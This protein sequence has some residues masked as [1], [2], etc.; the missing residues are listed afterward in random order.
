VLANTTKGL[1]HGT[2]PS[3]IGAAAR[4]ASNRL[5]TGPAAATAVIPWRPL[6]SRAG[7][8]GTGFPQPK[9]MRSMNNVPAGS[10]WALGLRVSRPIAQGIRDQR[11]RELVEGQSG[12]QGGDHSAEE[13]N[14]ELHV[15]S[16]EVQILE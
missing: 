9:P 12:D 4:A 1:T 5:E 16:Q 10:R 11:V 13:D 6:R 3:L 15:D 2:Q 8:T 14:E 7:F